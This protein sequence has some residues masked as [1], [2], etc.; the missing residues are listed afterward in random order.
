[1]ASSAESPTQARTGYCPLGCGYYD[2]RAACVRLHLIQH[3]NL[4]YDEAQEMYPDA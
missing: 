4:D 2:P 1:M 3:H